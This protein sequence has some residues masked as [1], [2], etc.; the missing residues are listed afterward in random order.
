VIDDVI[1]DCSY[2]DK[3]KTFYDKGLHGLSAAAEGMQLPFFH[4][5]HSTGVA[6]S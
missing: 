6:D 3:T 2:K 1:K 5:T 4:E